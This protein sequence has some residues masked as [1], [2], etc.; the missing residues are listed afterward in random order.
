MALFSD[1]ERVVTGIALLAAVLLVGLIDNFFVMWLFLGVVYL[2]AFKEAVK[3]LVL[4]E[5]IFY[6]MLWVSGLLLRSIL[7]VMTCLY[8]QVLPMLQRLLITRIFLGEISFLLSTQLQEC[9][10]S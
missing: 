4:R 1:K 10:S 9:F 6:R 7:M 3:L 2:L 5:T 8:L